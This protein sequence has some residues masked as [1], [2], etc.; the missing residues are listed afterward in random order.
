MT[1]IF[2]ANDATFSLRG[3]A[4]V[5]RASLALEPGRMTVIIGP[6]G[7]GKS[8][9][10]KLASGELAP[11][12]GAVHSLGTPLSRLPAWR[13]ACRRAVMVQ[14]TRIAFPLAVHEVIRLGIEGVGRA[15]PR[16]AADTIVARALDAADI[17]ALA[18]RNVLTLSGGEQQRVHF[19]RALAQLE[20]GAA[21][22]PAQALFLDE[23]IASLDLCH[24]L[25]LL[26]AVR[27]LARAR[28]VAVLAILHDLNLASAFADRLVVLDQGRIIASGAPR[29]V[30]SPGLVRQVF[31]VEVTP[32]STPG[33]HA[34]ILVPHLATAA[35]L[36]HA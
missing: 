11:T 2:E 7:A 35:P 23:P 20:A 22:E 13:L 9:F 4:L 32:L 6:N 34:P 3:R 14:A 36:K 10:L 24:Q 1:A 17:A 27:A 26:E 19:A 29:S 31:R 18:A 21:S 28:G 15:L 30:L 8:T 33:G 5:S 12:S 25:G 16:A